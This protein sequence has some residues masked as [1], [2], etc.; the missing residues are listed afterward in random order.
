VTRR[1]RLR[2]AT[3]IRIS[4]VVAVCMAATAARAP[5]QAPVGASTRELVAV[6]SD[7]E[8]YLR[9]LQDIG[10]VPAY[11]WTVREFGPRE[12]QSLIPTTT[13]HP[14]A[15]RVRPAPYQNVDWYFLAP[16]AQATYNSTFPSGDNDGALWQGRGLT[17]ALEG[18][19]AGHIGRLSLTL[20]PMV[21]WA[22]NQSFP[23]AANGQTGALR[24]ADGVNPTTIDLPQRF[25][26]GSYARFD[27]GQSTLRLDLPVVAIGASTANQE[28]GPAI[29]NPIILGNNAPGFPHVFVGSSAPVDLWLIRVQGR[30]EWGRL[31]QSPYA[32]LQGTQSR[33]FM[34]GIVGSLSPRGLSNLEIGGARFFHTLWPDSGLTRHDF[35]RPFEGLLLSSVANEIGNGT[36]QEPDNQLASIF[37]RWVFPKSGLELYSEFGREDHNADLRDFTQEPDHDAAYLI[38]LQKA[39]VRKDSSYLVFHGEVVNS[40][41]SHLQLGRPQTVF[42]VHSPVVQG[43]TEDGQIL[44]SPSVYGGGG[45]SFALDRYTR[46][47]RWTVAWQKIGRA[48]HLGVDGLPDGRQADVV[49]SVT[50]ER[51]HN[52]R[53]AIITAGLTLSDDL[54]RDFGGDKG[55]VR[56]AVSVIPRW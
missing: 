16:R 10:L 6:N 54:N 18:G 33:R 4:I 34:S 7:V 13:S 28:W 9:V 27:P 25:G 51:V 19:V 32:V 12:I 41:I 55:N 40:R 26:N 5:A 31:D 14:W 43:H 22:Q 30:V 38:G 44:G 46:D 3:T 8:R 1:P 2:S 56:V 52:G 20:D 35:L 48:E 42:Y 45:F 36:G 17:T 15:E 37:V 11:P 49:H 24:F 23:L 53:Q 50:V 39:W 21:F 29:D 47:G